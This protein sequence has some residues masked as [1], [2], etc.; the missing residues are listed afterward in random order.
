MRSRHSLA[1]FGMQQMRSLCIEKKLKRVCMNQVQQG[2]SEA[3]DTIESLQAVIRTQR[4]Q[5]DVLLASLQGLIAALDVV[6][7]ESPIEEARPACPA[8]L[9]GAMLGNPRDA[10]FH[11]LHQLLAR[12]RAGA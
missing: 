2:I 9:G 10:Q 1:R 7:P 6:V 11:T 5:I 3:D 8:E 4:A 12:L